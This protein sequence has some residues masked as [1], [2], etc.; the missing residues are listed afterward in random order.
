[1][2]LVRH[3][4]VA[5]AGEDATLACGGG[6]CGSVAMLPDSGDVTP[7]AGPDAGKDGGEDASASDGAIQ[8][9]A[10]G[11]GLHAP[12]SAASS[13]AS[14]STPRDSPVPTGNQ[15]RTR[16]SAVRDR[17]D[18]RRRRA[19]L[20]QGSPRG[21]RAAVGH[22]GFSKYAPAAVDKARASWTEV[23]INEYR[24]VASFSEVL[25]GARRR[26]GPARP[27]RH[28]E[29][30][31]RGRVLA[32]RAREPDGDGA[33]RRR[34]AP[35]RLRSLHRAAP[36]VDSHAARQRARPPRW[37]HRR[38][39]QRRHGHGELRVDVARASARGLRDDPPRRGASPPPGGALLR[40]GAVTYR[41]TRASSPRP[42]L[43]RRPSRISPR[44]GSRKL[45]GPRR[46][47]GPKRISKRSG[48]SARRSSRRSRR[49]SWSATSST[50][51]RSRLRSWRGASEPLGAEKR[52]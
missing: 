37:L 28:D 41:R 14:W 4:D 33:R 48:G 20:P 32:R 40:M 17:V 26:E 46:R 9:D 49:R 27:A 18:G 15:E 16:E 36:R 45:R 23:A 24:A 5:D 34:A 1:M 19:S 21:R 38:D 30:L 43:A 11:V 25:R 29:R 42:G 44:S 7:D 2:G 51:Q 10:G 8:D 22:R 50:L 35:G 12:P 3:P 6:P 31:P 52:R 47:R 39:V 13:S